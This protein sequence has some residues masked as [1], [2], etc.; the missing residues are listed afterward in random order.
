VAVLTVVSFPL[1]VVSSVLAW[2]GWTGVQLIR[3]VGGSA[4]S[5]PD[6]FVTAMVND[7]AN[8]SMTDLL[9]LVVTFVA[10]PTLW[11]ALS[12]ALTPDDSTD[13]YEKAMTSASDSESKAVAR[14]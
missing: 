6:R 5:F 7:P 14:R 12:I 8:L 3:H 13:H 1:T 4:A 10:L 11:A 2:T 9:F